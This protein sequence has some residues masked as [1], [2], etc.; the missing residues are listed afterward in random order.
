MR[1]Y[2]LP[3]Q[4]IPFQILLKAIFHKFYFVHSWILCSKWNIQWIFKICFLNTL[5]QM[6]HTV[7][8]QNMFCKFFKNL[9][10]VFRNETIGGF[11][12]KIIVQKIKGSF[13]FCHGWFSPVPALVP[14]KARYILA[15]LFFMSERKHFSN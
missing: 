6:E 9:L 8:I 15:I 5:F 13:H 4:T 11:M 10:Y 12:Q 3:K 7:D 2:G 14:L 1:E